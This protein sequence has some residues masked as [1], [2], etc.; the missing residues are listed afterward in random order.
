MALLRRE[1]GDPGARGAREREQA[2]E[3]VLAGGPQ[4][5]RG[6]AQGA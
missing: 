2:G 6:R 3:V 5:R 1:R 4:Q